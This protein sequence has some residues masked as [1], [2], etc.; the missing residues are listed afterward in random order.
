MTEGGSTVIPI[1]DLFY[2][3]AGPH[4]VSGNAV[5]LNPARFTQA[6]GRE[7]QDLLGTSIAQLGAV[8]GIHRRT[9]VPAAAVPIENLL[10]R[11]RAALERAIEIGRIAKESG[12]LPE[13]DTVEELLDLIQLAAED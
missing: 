2:D 10:Y 3:D 9:P 8:S 11:G 7:L 1:S 5:P 6:R 12:T 13:A 4:I